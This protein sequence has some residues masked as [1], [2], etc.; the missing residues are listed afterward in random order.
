MIKKD[1]IRLLRECD[2]GVKM[3]ISALNESMKYAKSTELRNYLDKSKNDNNAIQTEV[4]ELLHRYHDDGKDPS[5]VAK[6]M[7][8][9][10]TNMKLAVNES[11]DAIAELITD[12]CNM[13]VK[14]L[15]HYLNRYQEA[16]EKSKQLAKKLITLEER[17]SVDMRQFL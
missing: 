16:D 5:P 2:S 1:T 13:G 14:S 9:I 15:S 10:K 4:T 11:D 17:L 6:S 8:W 7:S 12:G 3:G